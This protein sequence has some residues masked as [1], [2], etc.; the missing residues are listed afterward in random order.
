MA[1]K[2]ISDLQVLQACR[3][4]A[5]FRSVHFVD[6]ILMTETG[7]CAKVC[8]RAMERAV[9]RGLIDYGVSLR[10]AWATSEGLTMLDQASG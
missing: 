2:D 3:D 10:T 4:Y 9:R 5:A 8:E 6:D 1:T 7:E